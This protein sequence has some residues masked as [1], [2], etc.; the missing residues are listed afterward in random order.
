MLSIGRLLEKSD[1]R[2]ISP[3]AI[4]PNHPKGKRTAQAAKPSQKGIVIRE[5]TTSDTK[6][7][8]PTAETKPN[9]KNNLSKDKAKAKTV[10][11]AKAHVKQ[12]VEQNPV[13]L[14]PKE[15][16]EDNKPTK[17]LRSDKLKPWKPTRKHRV[18]GDQLHLLTLLFNH[19]CRNQR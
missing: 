10:N 11:Q 16:Q 9:P 5:P 3:I 17:S 14:R 2:L 7:I 19:M 4:R 6:R 13:N 12:F 18:T 1:K 15:A 8:R